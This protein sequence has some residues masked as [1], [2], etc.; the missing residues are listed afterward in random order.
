[1]QQHDADKVKKKADQVVKAEIVKQEKVE[2]AVKNET[3]KM[4][5]LKKAEPP[6]LAALNKTKQELMKDE[7][8]AKKVKAELH[9]S[10]IVQLD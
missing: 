6:N 10:P 3:K 4:E 1:M 9:F 8:K 2:T 5:L 7:K